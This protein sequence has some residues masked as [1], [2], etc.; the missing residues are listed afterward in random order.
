MEETLFPMPPEIEPDE[1][2]L[3]GGRPRLKRPNREQMAFRPSNLEEMV[4]EDHPVR[5]IWSF[6]EELDLSPLYAQIQAVEGGPG[7]STIDPRLLMALWLYATLEGVGSAR[8]LD[9]LCQEHI[10]YLWIL[11]GVTVNYHTL[12]DFRVSQGALLDQLLSQ[13]VASLMA[14]GLAHLERTAQDGLR[15]RASAGKKSFRGRGKLEACLRQAE[16]QVEMLKAEL[17]TDSGASSRR[18]RAARQRARRDRTARVR[19]ALKQMEVL[20]EQRSKSTRKEKDRKPARASTTDPDARIMKMPDGGFRPA[21]NVQ[22][23]VDTTSQLIVGMRVTNAGVDQG[24]MGPMVEQERQRYGRAAREHLVDGGFA[25]HADIQQVADKGVAVYAPLPEVR[26]VTKTS[27]GPPEPLP[28]SVIAWRERM[29]TEEAK[30]IYKQRAS[31]VE[32]V[33]AILCNRGLR[34]FTVRGLEKVNAVVLWF[35]L[36]H[37]LLIGHKLRQAL[38]PA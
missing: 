32:W 22:M 5:L 16:A 14:E 13:S 28:P 21:Y 25:T 38:V 9:R 17:E 33:N 36:L 7:Q 15:V 6:V 24:Q 35:S 1:N 8:A 18:Q 4:P 37:N 29:Q 23:D 27:H 2:E 34:Q 31:S 10:A 11:G 30:A 26:P 12:A 19:R 3:L 20:E